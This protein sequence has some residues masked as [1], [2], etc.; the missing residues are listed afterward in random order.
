[1][2]VRV[3][4]DNNFYH[5]AQD[6]IKNDDISSPTNSGHVLKFSEERQTKIWQALGGLD[7]EFGP[8]LASM[9]EGAILSLQGDNPEKISIVCHLARELSAILPIYIPGIPVRQKPPSNEQILKEL[10]R[11][12]AVL[13]SNGQTTENDTKIRE[14]VKNL[15]SNFQNQ[16]SQR[17]QIKAIVD[18]HPTLSTRPAYLNEEFIKQWMAVH[19]YFVKNSHHHE[20]RNKNVSSNSEAELEANWSTLEGLIHRVLVKEPFFN[21]IQEIDKILAISHPNEKNADELMRLIVELE[22]RRY[23]FDKCSNP[24]WLALLDKRGAFSS[25]QEPVKRDK[26]IQ[27]VGWPESQYLSRIASQKPQEVY[28]II[29]DLTS[30]NQSVLDDFLDAA[31]KSPVGIASQ[32][33]KIIKDKGWMR[34]LYNLRLPDK[35]ADLMEKLAAEGKTDDAISLAEEIFSLRIYEPIRTSD[36]SN[37]HFPFIHPDAKPYFDEWQFGEIVQKKTKVLASVKPV[38]L[39]EVF[40]KKLQDALKLE[41]RDNSESED[42]F[43]EYSHIWR[44]N[45]EHVRNPNREDAKNILIDGLIN[46]IDTNKD[47]ADV[48]ASFIKILQQCHQALFIR[49]EIFLYCTVS[50]PPLGE[51][52]KILTKKKIVVSYNLRREYLPLLE[53]H[54]SQL[55]EEGQNT[56]LKTI[57][58]GPNFKKTEDMSEEQFDAMVMRWQSLYYQRIKKYLP[59]PYKEKFEK[60]AGKYGQ[61]LDDDGE[62]RVTGGW[63]G[64]ESPLTAE[65]LAQLDSEKAIEYMRDY[66]EPEDSFAK[67]SSSGLGIIFSKVV[68]ENPE[69]YIPQADLL[70][71]HKVKPLY[72]YQFL[73]GLRETIKNKK[74][75]DWKPV[76]ELCHSVLF[77]D[78]TNESP[79][80]V[81]NH[82]LNWQ[83]VRKAI[84]DL[85]GAILG[86][87]DC[88]VSLDLKEPIWKI[89]S[90]LSTDDD[91]TPE[92]EKKDGGGNLDPMTLAINT[93]RGEAIHAVVNY[94][95]WLARNQSKDAPQHANK[96][97]AEMQQVLDDHLDPSKDFS[98]AI[99]SVY[100]WRLPNLFY[101]NREWV[102]SNLEIIFPPQEEMRA[103]FMAALEGYISN[104]IY[105]DIFDTLKKV[106]WNAIALLGTNQ[107]K[108]G[109]RAA[110]IDERLPQHLMV[111]YIRDPKHDDLIKHFFLNAP[112][113]ARGQAIN[114][115]GRVILRE[116]PGYA[117][118][119]TVINRVR[120]LW[121]QRISTSGTTDIEELQEFG[122]W[123]K[124]SPLSHKDTIDRLLKTLE[125]SKGITDVAYE[126]VE[127]LQNYAPELPLETIIALD[128]IA[129]AEREYH[130]FS[131]KKEEYKETI[132]RVKATGNTEA[133][134]KANDLINFLG[135]RG[136]IEFRELL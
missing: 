98:L 103:F 47:N 38:D 80:I 45:L 65:Q 41:K 97:P 92:Y 64:D 72:I 59:S 82:E 10:N 76:I 42:D 95:L 21:A 9:Y 60:M 19:E 5:M 51:I 125:I 2:E 12:V 69:K 52:E 85:M 48:I 29:K 56:I 16:P 73:N 62:I 122:W 74:K 33:V 39:F 28:D 128:L 78:K 67:S 31:L 49:I 109:Y 107:N 127:E 4:V 86:D 96:M 136:F 117:D 26:Y 133:I 54:F 13:D 101:L 18:T 66:K 34:G 11:I 22:H 57:D 123:F 84:V 27:F 55:S 94:G 130:E 79:Q 112:A 44:P 113:K 23:F 8:H 71:K 90:E 30:D 116:I 63:I 129:R 53:K 100:G 104:N 132:R 43:Y 110:D 81:N 68:S 118:K 40:V 3:I 93:V 70:L 6:E 119:E 89:L 17:D 61:V 120:Q 20:L 121:D 32:Y 134:K 14:I 35:A 99:R 88:D 91:P 36:D 25:P 87:K 126:I 77:T 102:V 106:Y 37:N 135:S 46:L 83:S 124:Q 24:D 58:E 131:Y 108:A 1:M 75:L 7:S 15:S 50:Q 111:V 115:T 114:F 105:N